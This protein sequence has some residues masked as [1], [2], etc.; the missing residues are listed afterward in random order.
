M[1]HRCKETNILTY[2]K[3][4]LSF[5]SHHLIKIFTCPHFLVRAG[6]ILSRT[7]NRDENRG[8]F[9]IN[10]VFHYFYPPPA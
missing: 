3:C 10:S 6:Y 8:T 5:S 7:L 9:I 2:Q 4:E 1:S